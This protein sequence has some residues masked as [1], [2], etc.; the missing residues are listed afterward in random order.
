MPIHDDT[1]AVRTGYGHAPQ[2]QFRGRL[3]LQVRVSSSRSRRAD[4]L[5]L[6]GL[7]GYRVGEHAAA[8]AMKMLG[9][10]SWSG[11]P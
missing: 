11:A 9:S 5:S 3:T 4:L 10:P 2:D 8:P 7:Q 1:D 6:A